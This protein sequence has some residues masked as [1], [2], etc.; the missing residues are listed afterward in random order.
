[1]FYGTRANKCAEEKVNYQAAEECKR[2]LAGSRAADHSRQ[3]TNLPQYLRALREQSPQTHV[4]LEL[5]GQPP[6]NLLFRRVFICP[7]VSRRSYT[8][9]RPF[10]AVDGS[11]LKGFFQQTL[12]LAVSVDAN[13]QYILLAWAIVESEN[14]ES[15]RYFFRHLTTAIP[16]IVDAPATVMSDRQKGLLTAEE[17]LGP[18]AIRLVCVEHL[19][20]NFIK[21]AGCDLEH[22]CKPKP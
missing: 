16:E 5:A 15:W 9:C 18:N 10:F 4:H 20:K 3:Y 6:N 19:R 14:A 11:F 8:N 22:H 17:V 21:K 12:L 2:R 7:D 1:L 13:N